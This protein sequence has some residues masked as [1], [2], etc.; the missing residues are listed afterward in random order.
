MT[1]LEKKY[2]EVFAKYLSL[3]KAGDEV[4]VTRERIRQILNKY[5]NAETKELYDK[6]QAKLRHIGEVCAVCKR[7][8]EQVRAASKDLCRVCYVYK[9]KGR[10]GRRM[11]LIFAPTRCT[12]CAVPFNGKINAT[13]R[14]HNICF[15]CYAKT[16]RYRENQRRYFSKPEIKEKKRIQFNEYYKKHKERLYAL[17]KVRRLLNREKSNAYA[18]AYYQKNKEKIKA[19]FRGYYYKRKAEREAL[20]G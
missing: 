14:I 11:R 1:D 12:K 20:Q 8:L 16:P 17:A 19:R 2:M 5:K 4:G 3:T 15:R 9:K 18:R 6:F 7:S 13:R 10:P